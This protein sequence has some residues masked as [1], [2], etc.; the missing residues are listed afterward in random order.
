MNPL[1]PSE[2]DVKQ[3]TILSVT[4][5]DNRDST[6][7][8]IEE[9]GCSYPDD[10]H[11]LSSREEGIKD[12]VDQA[13]SNTSAYKSPLIPQHVQRVEE[14]RTNPFI[15]QP[16]KEFE[17]TGIKLQPLTFTLN[18]LREY[19]MK[20]HAQQIEH[21][22]FI[23]GG[24]ATNILTD[25]RHP[26]NDID[27]NWF[28]GNNFREYKT[29][30][31]AFLGKQ[32][33]ELHGINLEGE[34]LN[35]FIDD[36]YIRSQKETDTFT[37]IRLGDLDVKFVLEQLTPN[38]N[39]APAD[40]FQI[41][42]TE[43]YVVCIDRGKPCNKKE[44]SE[45]LYDAEHRIYRFSDWRN[46]REALFRLVFKVTQGYE[47]K[48]KSEILTGV[49]QQMIKEASWRMTN[50][51]NE[52]RRKFKLQQWN[53]C[54][55]N[56][57]GRMVHLLNT[58][59]QGVL[60]IQKAEAGNEQECEAYISA[61]A[62]AWYS[63]RPKILTKFTKLIKDHPKEVPHLLNVIR[64]VFLTEWLRK[65]P[66]VKAFSFPFS[67]K[68]APLRMQFGLTD[69]KGETH[70]FGLEDSHDPTNIA[71]EFISSWQHLEK[72]LSDTDDHSLFIEMAKDLGFSSLQ[73]DKNTRAR[74]VPELM[75]IFDCAPMQEAA[76]LF[77]S[78]ISPIAYYEK[79]IKL[80]NSE[81]DLQTSLELHQKLAKEFVFRDKRIHGSA[82]SL[83][84]DAS[85][86][87]EEFIGVIN[88]LHVSLRAAK[89]SNA[90]ENM[91]E[92]LQKFLTGLSKDQLKNSHTLRKLI[93]RA[94]SQTLSGKSI[95]YSNGI[96]R[97]SGLKML[98]TCDEICDMTDEEKASAAEAILSAFENDLNSITG[99][100]IPFI[101]KL[102]EQLS[103]QSLPS[104]YSALIIK[105][106]SYLTSKNLSS[107]EKLLSDGRIEETL[108]SLKSSVVS[109]INDPAI[110]HTA[111]ALVSDTI[112]KAVNSDNVECC[113][114]AFELA[115]MILNKPNLHLNPIL[116]EPFLQ[117]IQKIISSDLTTHYSR[118]PAFL[119]LLSN[120]CPLN[121]DLQLHIKFAFIE[122]IEDPLEKAEAAINH[123]VSIFD[124]SEAIKHV[125]NITKFIKKTF[126][127]NLEIAQ[128]PTEK[129]S[130]LNRTIIKTCHQ[131]AS[132]GNEGQQLA[133]EIVDA[134]RCC[135]P[136]SENCVLYFQIL[137]SIQ[138]NQGVVCIE[139][140]CRLCKAIAGLDS[141]TFNLALDA[142][143]R[144]LKSNFVPS[145]WT[146]PF[147]VAILKMIEF[148][149]KIDRNSPSAPLAAEILQTMVQ[150]DSIRHLQG[151]GMK[152]L[153]ATAAM[154]S[155]ALFKEM[156]MAVNLEN[157]ATTDLLLGL[158]AKLTLEP[159]HADKFD[160][161]APLI[162]K[163]M[164]D[165][166]LESDEKVQNFQK[167]LCD[168]LERNFAKQEARNFMLINLLALTVYDKE[169]GPKMCSAAISAW[170]SLYPNELKNIT[171]LLSHKPE[172]AA[173][174]INVIRGCLMLISARLKLP[175]LQKATPL[176]Y[177]I[178]LNGSVYHLVSDKEHYPN[179]ISSSF[180]ESLFALDESFDNA[181]HV[182]AL[183]VLFD[184]LNPPI[185]I[186]VGKESRSELFIELIDIFEKPPLSGVDYSVSPNLSPK[187][188][189]E[190]L[191][192]I[193]QATLDINTK[194][195][196]Q[197]RIC[198]AQ[199]DL[200]VRNLLAG[201]I[202]GEDPAA[203]T[204]LAL[205]DLLKRTRKCILDAQINPENCLEQLLNIL[206]ELREPNIIQALHGQPGMLNTFV[207]SIQNC[208][209]IALSK[210]KSLPALQ[211]AYSILQLSDSLQL[212][213]ER[214]N[215]KVFSKIFEICQTIDLT[216]PDNL[217]FLVKVLEQS[218]QWGQ[219]PPEITEKRAE[220]QPHIY[221]FMF[222]HIVKL[223]D[224]CGELTIAE[225]ISKY[226]C[227]LPVST[228]NDVKQKTYF[229]LVQKFF[230][231][232][233]DNP[234]GTRLHFS[235]VVAQKLLLEPNPEFDQNLYNS[236]F[237][238]GKLLASIK[239]SDAGSFRKQVELK[240]SGIT[241]LINLAKSLTED[242]N[243]ID[244]IIPVLLSYMADILSSPD[245]DKTIWN[246]LSITANSFLQIESLPKGFQEK[247]EALA[248]L[249]SDKTHHNYKEAA[250][251]LIHAAI[252]VNPEFA[253][254]IIS[255]TKF[256]N[257]L[258]L[259]ES[260][261]L[262]FDMVNTFSAEG[263]TS[264]ALKAWGLLKNA[265]WSVYESIKRPQIKITA[266]L[267]LISHLS[268]SNDPR[269]EVLISNAISYLKKVF[270]REAE[271]IK[272]SS[273]KHKDEM[274]K[275]FN[276]A[277]KNLAQMHSTFGTQI[278]TSL[279]LLADRNNI[280]LQN[281]GILAYEAVL[282]CST[283]KRE[284]GFDLIQSY[285]DHAMKL[286][287]TEINH[288]DLIA[289]TF[290]L[291]CFCQNN[292]NIAY[293]PWAI[294]LL[295][296]LFS[297]PN[298]D[299]NDQQYLL[300][301]EQFIQLLDASVWNLPEF[302][303]LAKLMAEK[304]IISTLTFEG[305]SKFLRILVEKNKDEFIKAHWQ[306]FIHAG[307]VTPF[308]TPMLL[309][310]LLDTGK[311]PFIQFYFEILPTLGFNII[312]HKNVLQACEK[313]KDPALYKLI[314][315]HIIKDSA[316]KN[317]EFDPDDTLDTLR[318]LFAYVD[319]IALRKQNPSYLL[320][321]AKVLEDLLPKKI[322]LKFN[323]QFLETK[324]HILK[325]YV[326]CCLKTKTPEFLEKA[327]KAIILNPGCAELDLSLRVI[328]EYFSKSYSAPLNSNLDTWADLINQLFYTAL[329]IADL[330]EKSLDRL[331]LFSFLDSLLSRG[332]S[333][334]DIGTVESLRRMLFITLNT[335]VISGDKAKVTEFIPLVHKMVL[336]LS[337]HGHILQLGFIDEQFAHEANGYKHTEYK[338]WVLSYLSRHRD[339]L[340]TLTVKSNASAIRD[341]FRETIDLMP[342]F[343]LYDYKL[344]LETIH[345]LFKFFSQSPKE[346]L[347]PM[348][349][350]LDKG[351]EKQFFSYDFQFLLSVSRDEMASIKT[352]LVQAGKKLEA[353][354]I[355]VLLG[356]YDRSLMPTIFERYNVLKKKYDRTLSK[357]K[358]H[359]LLFSVL[360]DIHARV[361]IDQLANPKSQL[362]ESFTIILFQTISYFDRTLLGTK[363]FSNMLLTIFQQTVYCP[364]TLMTILSILKSTP[365][366]KHSSLFGKTRELLASPH[367]ANSLQRSFD[368]ISGIEAIEKRVLER[369][370]KYIEYFQND[371]EL[372]HLKDQQIPFKAAEQILNI[373]LN[374][375]SNEN[376][377][378]YFQELSEQATKRGIDL[379]IFEDW[380][381]FL[382]P[383]QFAIF[384]VQNAKF[385]KAAKLQLQTAVAKILSLNPIV[386]KGW[387]KHKERLASTH[388]K[389]GN[390]DSM[391]KPLT[392]TDLLVQIGRMEF[393]PPDAEPAEAPQTVAP[394][395]AAPVQRLAPPHQPAPRI[396]PARGR[397]P[398][399]K[400]AR[401]K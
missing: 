61:I 184:D 281:A 361:V 171:I 50:N 202:E 138:S 212:F 3:S 140:A 308:N 115:E 136:D 62:T 294:A 178:D 307:S 390:P 85:T 304:K 139:N 99:E 271:E 81:I 279:S 280:K 207:E 161:L 86:N 106:S 369:S 397:G 66:V 89:E 179:I 386:K 258:S 223:I 125:E 98:A 57:S 341:Q 95:D 345:I 35:K 150:K 312:S 93:G 305:L 360:S 211:N 37:Y 123:C 253:C 344:G 2:M 164:E 246:T 374:I 244:K 357:D 336:I 70:Y 59:A 111:L 144:V 284:P 4:L 12:P 104:A 313:S 149:P 174:I 142:L 209:D 185:K 201:N 328:K 9:E 110:R 198:D 107:Q 23:K 163:F 64:G 349:D 46:T 365:W 19:L 203:K 259:E 287:E 301:T 322:P 371:E 286:S 71:L 18:G 215:L 318:P 234:S 122:I 385:E 27:I 247:I 275:S 194:L 276:E 73:L 375:I 130:N 183:G 1:C 218:N 257:L 400:G 389:G 293:R 242:L 387:E 395:V 31:Y 146:R 319:A 283:Q 393:L 326:N 221:D 14:I 332:W 372:S 316:L 76:K 44:F 263:N 226:L 58:V 249:S 48:S 41:S 137:E 25:G 5:A 101:N 133:K 204:P 38:S 382:I 240:Q 392:I 177:E 197:N 168:F 273:A 55:L 398:K 310:V 261:N 192:V 296:K 250:T 342:L 299:L 129:L 303:L 77:K 126:L 339:H 331:L 165:P 135:F 272:L 120:A 302:D 155:Q 388:A 219:L 26:F 236:I 78:H 153:D 238:I 230:A 298:F 343:K 334:E 100:H 264:A 401:K 112:L 114:K 53:H 75:N 288:K 121:K 186:A 232:S 268:K 391:Q 317:L 182:Q 383:L 380:T 96:T 72:K 63:R 252:L 157:S 356:N 116:H 34:D 103:K 370:L 118:I 229:S 289:L 195:T 87:C 321:M 315:E 69:E 127:T 80:S 267:Y 28:V 364:S 91:L 94:V 327:I 255:Q 213:G 367:C 148:F 65:S 348:L 39:V 368:S 222:C 350:L 399:A 176:C 8:Q 160:A 325:C 109:A 379:Y 381:H 32:I 22:G 347:K 200:T 394:I 68:D 290:R 6:S 20:E 166:G 329:S 51:Y 29:Y 224:R 16:K 180:V 132:K 338:G 206:E 33:N 265:S 172:E 108:E 358:D 248:K 167:S 124:K 384:L 175:T 237:D 324:K 373:L 21:T 323:D 359:D 309:S 47:I 291:I 151:V 256:Y 363:M 36:N 205:I 189:F 147:A 191:A 82:L 56:E 158:V 346:F 60:G 260:D 145:K 117:L 187:S 134:A 227:A 173:N 7:P 270:T 84:G 231:H 330:K 243:L 295:N 225:I 335:I 277:T 152:L 102:L 67:Q 13:A 199:I 266:T 214:E 141:D 278:A 43:N 228:L 396:T 269:K 262:L 254:S 88:A 154:G 49:V 239:L 300:G 128:S 208:I 193:A 355:K 105:I 233:I 217:V 169:R 285:F 220:I 333:H 378:N 245:E 340:K 314:E 113:G 354:V 241:L 235:C 156:L 320:K 97:V 79:L 143:N 251:S 45:A 17:A 52:L 30:L 131:L 40:S 170:K 159:S 292:P 353:E 92:P 196:L 24:A 282:L 376:F 311:T 90:K 162:K 188:F 15:L 54:P 74:I 362:F 181:M 377:K 210:S 190:K 274:A 11:Q 351:H 306:Q 216:V 366:L 42:F 297:F 83:M 352:K 10:L 337:K 119:K